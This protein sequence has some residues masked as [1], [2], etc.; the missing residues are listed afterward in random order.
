MVNGDNLAL[1]RHDLSNQAKTLSELVLAQRATND[2]I[3]TLLT[4]QAV[5]KLDRE[6]LQEKIDKIEKR[7]DNLVGIGRWVLIAF[8]TYF[9]TS[10]AAF[11]VKGGLNIGP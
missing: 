5:R 6:N 10:A 2:T 4:D 8:M 11:I 1:V 7:L 3:H 9:I